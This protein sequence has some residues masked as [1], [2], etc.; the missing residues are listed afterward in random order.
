MSVCM[1]VC[2]YQFERTPLHLSCE[3]GH[4]DV[5]ALLLDRGA[6]VNFRDEVRLNHTHAH[7]YSCAYTYART[8]LTS[9]MYV[10]LTPN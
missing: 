6:E 5:T 3:G 2:V 7:T 4:L 8:V 1:R 9:R 10:A